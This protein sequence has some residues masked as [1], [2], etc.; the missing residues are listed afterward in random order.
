[1]AP[2]SYVFQDTMP[3][4][5]QFIHEVIMDLS[6]IESRPHQPVLHVVDRGT[7]FSATKFLKGE[8]Q[9]MFGILWYPAGYI[10]T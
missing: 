7:H 10:F 1:M 3:D 8:V 9:K 5:I 6:W 4:S 2:R